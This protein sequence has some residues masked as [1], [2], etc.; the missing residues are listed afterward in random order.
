[1][2]EGHGHPLVYIKSLVAPVRPTRRSAV[3]L[4]CVSVNGSM[5]EPAFDIFYVHHV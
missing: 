5:A 3:E 1:M 4:D 2:S